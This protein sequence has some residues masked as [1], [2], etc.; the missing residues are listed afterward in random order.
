MIVLSG[1]AIVGLAAVWRIRPP[2]GL[3]AVAGAAVLVGIPFVLFFLIGGVTSQAV[4]A[5][6]SI[7]LGWVLA[8]GSATEALT[9]FN[10]AV[11][12]AG[13]T[14]AELAEPMARCHLELG[15][16]A[17][18]RALLRRAT[19]LDPAGSELRR[20]YRQTAVPAQ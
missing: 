5:S 14:V 16:R 1:L 13:G 17:Q 3:G 6:L 12:V 8:T 10:K 20:L 19:R 9:L 11:Q 2:K 18:A 15:H 4:G 7:W